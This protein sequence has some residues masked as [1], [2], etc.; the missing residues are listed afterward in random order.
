MKITKKLLS[1]SLIPLFLLM[2]G[3]LTSG[4]LISDSNLAT[5]SYINNYAHRQVLVSKIFN[6]IGYGHGIHTF[7]NYILRGDIVYYH[8]AKKDF[9]MAL[10]TIQEY[11]SL[12]N[13]DP[14]ELNTLTTLRFMI[15][16][17]KKKLETAKELINKNIPIN[18][19]DKQIKV[20]DTPSEFAL[21]NL[22]KY[23]LRKKNT[24]LQLLTNSQHQAYTLTLSIFL[25]SFIIACL[26]SGIISKRMLYSIKKILQISNQISKEEY[27]INKKVLFKFPND[28]LK[29]LANQILD[30][31]SKLRDAF[32]NLKKSN[33]DLEQF[34]YVASHD[35]QSP[36]KKISNY[37]DFI[38]LDY[39]QEIPQEAQNHLKEI[40][41]LSVNMVEQIN[42]VL[43]YS[44]LTAEKH[45]YT[46]LNIHDLLD[47]VQTNLLFNE[48][49]IEYD[50][51]IKQ[52]E[53]FANKELIQV[54]LQ[55]IFSNALKFKKPN[56]KLHLKIHT[57]LNQSKFNIKICDNGIGFDQKHIKTILR[58]FGRLHSKNDFPGSGIGLST[59]KR[60]AEIHQGELI[61][62]AQE[63]VGSCFTLIL[64]QVNVYS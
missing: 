62:S 36:I 20:D 45:H 63:G 3:A 40:K 27:N 19:I 25:I 59:C 21:K 33:E 54:Y 8:R 9:T 13:L 31:G 22:N 16:E 61:I 57:D 50:I 64:P 37:V 15:L 5:Q 55:N 48:N 51:Q 52:N 10:T 30:M 17:Y 47:S 60:I 44:K 24:E 18:E 11:M 34:A 6:Q 39:N 7:K 46:R 26:L 12:D 1:A 53:F 49:D 14:I 38:E 4:K 32:A 43:N 35:L 56:Q 41:E 29:V 2:I 42:A 58:P 23:F 28:E